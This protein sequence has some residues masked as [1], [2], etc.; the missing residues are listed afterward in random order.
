MTNFSLSSRLSRLRFFGL[1][2]IA[3][4]VFV[5]TTNLIITLVVNKK[6]QEIKVLFKSEGLFLDYEKTSFNLL[7]G[8]TLRGLVVGRGDRTVFS[9]Q[10][11]NI[12][13]DVFSIVK[14]KVNVK[15]ID[16]QGVRFQ[17][18]SFRQLTDIGRALLSKV[19]KTIGFY[20][21]TF[22]K[23]QDIELAG[24]IDMDLQGYLSCL[25]NRIY[26]SRG[27]IIFKSIRVPTLEGAEVLRGSGFMKP[28]DYVFEGESEEKDF[29]ITRCEFSNESLKFSGHGRVLGAGPEPGLDFEMNFLNMILDDFPVINNEYL[30]A[31][32]VVD[33]VLKVKGPLA[34]LKTML[35]VKIVN[36]Q[37]NF[38]N[39]LSLTKI[40]GQGVVT[41]DRARGENISMQ[42]NEIPFRMDFAF[43]Q[44]QTPHLDL[45]LSAAYEV[46]GRPGFTL[47]YSADFLE[48]GLV[49]DIKSSLRSASRQTLNTMDLDFSGL[50]VTYD[51]DVLL[52]AEGFSASIA[53]ESG[54][55]EGMDEIF[56]RDFDF[57]DISGILRLQEG[58]FALEDLEGSCY[59]GALEGRFDFLAAEKGLYVKGE[60]HVRGVELSEFFEKTKKAGNVL[61][62]KLD[63]DLKFDSAA[64]DMFKGQLFVTKG[65]VGDDPLLHAVAQ[66]LGVPSLERIAFEELS[67]FFQGGR[68]EYLSQIKLR[69]PEVNGAMDGKITSY[70]TLD[71]YL[72]VN[73][74]TKLLNESKTFRK[75]LTYIRHDQPSVVFPF[76]ISSYVSSPRVLWLKNEFKE[77]IQNLLPERN[78][79]Y[80]QRQVNSLVEGVR[81]E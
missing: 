42:V 49:G 43:A 63:G 29:L 66:F 62:G 74:S 21:T 52:D 78:Q 1:A 46:L 18:Q 15:N 5:T 81:A 45:Q 79:R 51:E 68:G 13:F 40:N 77:K 76:R 44:N 55:Q 56:S 12:G 72:A 73:I 16:M 32:G 24:A 4:V 64:K 71:G 9:S 26:A 6:F 57:Q 3:L 35:N 59:R 38:F 19:D 61:L 8:L 34:D 80:L 41:R 67:M 14:Q 69:S 10:K 37:V 50:H 11:I 47:S 58:G 33:A 17:P 75:L 65:M 20:E 54:D 23:G 30:T 48:Q 28:F 53:V 36:S 39:A 70:D 22:F 31:R 7:H 25:K 2:V 27:R 60:T